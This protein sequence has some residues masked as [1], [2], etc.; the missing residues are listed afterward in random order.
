MRLAAQVRAPV[1]EPSGVDL[2]LAKRL[3][4]KYDDLP[5]L[6]VWANVFWHQYADP[7][8]EDPTVSPMRLFVS[9]IPD[10]RR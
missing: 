8:F 4:E 3:L 9:R 7:Y 10:I 1:R 2:G 5:Q 6:L